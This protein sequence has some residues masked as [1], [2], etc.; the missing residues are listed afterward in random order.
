MHSRGRMRTTQERYEWRESR[1]WRAVVLEVSVG[2][3]GLRWRIFLV[4][5]IDTRPD[6]YGRLGRAA[7]AS[8]G[9]HVPSRASP[10]W[11]GN[12][13][14]GSCT[15][16]GTPLSSLWHWSQLDLTHTSC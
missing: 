12:H 11:A 14:T 1:L 8:T 10:T 6:R 2:N 5:D 13:I 7:L 4:G 3:Q 9:A 15:R 16:H